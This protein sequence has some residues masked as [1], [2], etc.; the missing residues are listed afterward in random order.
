MHESAC[1]NNLDSGPY[2]QCNVRDVVF[3]CPPAAAAAVNVI[4]A[5]SVAG[6]SPGPAKP[7]PATAVLNRGPHQQPSTAFEPPHEH[8]QQFQLFRR[9]TSD[10]RPPQCNSSAFAVDSC[11]I[12]LAK[13]GDNGT[14]K[15]LM[16]KEEDGA[17]EDNS[18]SG[19]LKKLDLS[20]SKAAT[21]KRRKSAPLTHF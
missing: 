5:T 16:N 12:D 1:N 6:G 17:E 13:D 18:L 7:R 15:R 14:T 4:Y 2:S 8:L 9:T 20:R 10:L 21:A 11:F 19:K 3:P